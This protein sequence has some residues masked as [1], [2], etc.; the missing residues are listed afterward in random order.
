MRTSIGGPASI[1]LPPTETIYPHTSTAR[2]SPMY[3]VA[4][5]EILSGAL[6]AACYLSTVFAAVISYMLTLRF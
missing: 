1:Q 5:P 4:T 3:Y 6:E 2:R